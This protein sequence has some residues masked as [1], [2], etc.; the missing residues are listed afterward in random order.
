MA[1]VLVQRQH[2]QV[3][4]V[5]AATPGTVTTLATVPTVSSAGTGVTTSTAA[6]TTTTP[7]RTAGAP[8]FGLAATPAARADCARLGLDGETLA[9]LHAVNRSVAVFGGWVDL[10]V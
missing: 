2:A 1:P 6:S 9:G 10:V 7:L 4:Q 3:A 8:V 5:D